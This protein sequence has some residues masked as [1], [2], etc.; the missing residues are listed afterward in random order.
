MP[1][2]HEGKLDARGKKVAIIAGRFN[3]FV[4]HRLVDGAVDCLARHGA[5]DAS[6]HVYWV[7]GSFEIPQLAERLAQ[8]KQFDG[9]LCLG[10][11]IRGETQHFEVLSSSVVKAIADISLRAPVPVTHGLIT[12]D[13]ADQAMDRAGGKAGNKGWDGAL[14]L[15]EMM[16]IW[17][18]RAA[19]G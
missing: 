2:V 6:L 11:L 4:T 5:D 17:K 12:A 8:S 14:A 19:R 15:V 18:T 16:N 10:T 9:V 1:N 3:D 7:P 13:S